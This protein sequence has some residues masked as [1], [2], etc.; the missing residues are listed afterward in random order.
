MWNTNRVQKLTL[1][2]MGNDDIIEEMDEEDSYE[3]EGALKNAKSSS[4]LLSNTS[5][6]RAGGGSMAVKK[7]P[8]FLSEDKNR[9]DRTIIKRK[10][11]NDGL[12][13]G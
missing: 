8:A 5:F 4:T 13:L 3:L 6:R 7:K 10:T 12:G 11:T 9:R 2:A 1:S